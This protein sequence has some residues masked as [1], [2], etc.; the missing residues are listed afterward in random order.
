MNNN[1]A[2]L[3]IEIRRREEKEISSSNTTTTLGPHCNSILENLDPTMAW[4]YSHASLFEWGKEKRR[5]RERLAPFTPPNVREWRIDT[6][7]TP[8]PASTK[9]ITQHLFFGR[10]NQIAKTRQPIPKLFFVVV[11]FTKGSHALDSE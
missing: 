5:E 3:V 7:P 9:K 6:T 10:T 1:E 11:E 4:L 8:P 2:H